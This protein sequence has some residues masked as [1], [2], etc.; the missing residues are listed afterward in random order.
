[1]CL[2]RQL[3]CSTLQCTR[4]PWSLRQQLLHW[5]VSKNAGPS[6][7][8]WRFVVGCGSITPRIPILPGR[9]CEGSGWT[10]GCVLL[11][12]RSRVVQFHLPISPPLATVVYASWHH[13]RACDESRARP[14]STGLSCKHQHLFERPGWTPC[15]PTPTPTSTILDLCPCLAI[16]AVYRMHRQRQQQSSIALVSSNHPS[17]G[18]WCRIICCNRGS[19]AL[20]DP[21]ASHWNQHRSSEGDHACCKHSG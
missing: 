15:P 1:M 17:H 21:F 8:P 4:H 11:L 20:P 9:S 16:A 3:Q 19:C 10:S 14:R 18:C 2:C 6:C 5:L 7:D 12:W 13:S